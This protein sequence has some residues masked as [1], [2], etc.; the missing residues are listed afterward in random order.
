MLPQDNFGGFLPSL[1]QIPITAF[2]TQ[3]GDRYMLQAR[4]IGA[5]YAEAWEDV[6]GAF[7][8]SAVQSRELIRGLNEA[9]EFMVYRGVLVSHG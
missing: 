6:D 4:Y 5:H 9:S 3:M 7:P 8:L 1:K 2:M